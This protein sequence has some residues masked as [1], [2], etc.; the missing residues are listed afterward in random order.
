MAVVVHGFIDVYAVVNPS[1]T[2]GTTYMLITHRIVS[3]LTAIMSLREVT[4]SRLTYA[5][6]ISCRVDS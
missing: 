4:I 5:L 1:L 3:V 2:D 6:S